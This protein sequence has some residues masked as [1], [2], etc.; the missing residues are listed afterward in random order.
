[1][2]SHSINSNTLEIVEASMI[3]LCL[4]AQLELNHIGSVPDVPSPR[5]VRS[6][7]LGDGRLSKISLSPASSYVHLINDHR[8]TPCRKFG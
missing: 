6:S 2:A 5:N 8:Q 7:L 3:G 1:M 4:L